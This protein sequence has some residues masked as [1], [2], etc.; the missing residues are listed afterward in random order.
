M[1]PIYKIIV[2]GTR[3]VMFTTKEQKALEEFDA[4]VKLSEAGDKQRVVLFKAGI[5]I[6]EYN[7]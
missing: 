5:P 7:P 6:K 4:H 3:A 2:G 1:N